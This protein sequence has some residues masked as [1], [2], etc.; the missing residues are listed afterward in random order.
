MRIEQQPMRLNMQ[1]IGDHD[2]QQQSSLRSIA[3]QSC[4]GTCT[5][6]LAAFMLSACTHCSLM[7]EAL[8]QQS[9]HA[10]RLQASWK[11]AMVAGRASIATPWL[12]MICELSRHFGTRK[13]GLH[14]CRSLKGGTA[15]S[16]KF[17]I[18][19]DQLKS[20]RWRKEGGDGRGWFK[21]IATTAPIYMRPAFSMCD[22]RRRVQINML[23]VG[24]HYIA[25]LS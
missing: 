1:G 8:R 4:T 5:F 15:S 11:D 18:R 13:P 19:V 20:C 17:M 22:H 2:V 21:A 16:I 25:I 23:Q 24:R 12:Y 9:F 7:L 14:V 6:V 3:S 10:A